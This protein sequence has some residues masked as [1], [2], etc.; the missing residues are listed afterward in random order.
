MPHGGVKARR[1]L[2]VWL[3]A[4][5]RAE[6]AVL[7]FEVERQRAAGVQGDRAALDALHRR[8]GQALERTSSAPL[9]WRRCGARPAHCW[10]TWTLVE[11]RIAGRRVALIASVAWRARNLRADVH[12]V[13]SGRER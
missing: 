10:R 8:R 6:R 4:V 9:R 11:K 1:E 13:A 7:E 3:A 12:E 5:A 2:L